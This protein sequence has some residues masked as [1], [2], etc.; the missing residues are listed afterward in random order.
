VGQDDF[1][2]DIVNIVSAVPGN[3]FL[4]CVPPDSNGVSG[5]IQADPPSGGQNQQWVFAEP[6]E[7]PV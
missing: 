4:L 3:G 7:A 5:R 2:R 1:G 6:N